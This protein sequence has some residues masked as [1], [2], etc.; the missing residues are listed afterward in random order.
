MLT[1]VITFIL[2]PGPTLSKTFS[3]LDVSWSVVLFLISYNIGDTIGKYSAE[4]NNIFNTKSLNFLFF[5]RLV[6]FFTITVMAN[7]TDVEDPMINNYVFPFINQLL[8]AI[9]NGFC[10]SISF[11]S[12]RLLHHGLQ[13]LS[14]SLQEIRRRALRNDSP[15]RHHDRNYLGNSLR[16]PDW[17]RLIH[18]IIKHT[19]F[20]YMWGH[21]R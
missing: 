18:Y 1:F 16:L 20:Y 17:Y 9:T 6:F 7:G 3:D 21:Y 10:I 19:V 13:D 11:I 2:F 12:R 14:S 15:N 5:G 8:F 4:F